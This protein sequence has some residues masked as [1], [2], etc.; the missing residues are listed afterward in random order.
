MNH[1]SRSR[2]LLLELLFDLVIFA[3]CAAVCVAILVSARS[4]SRES[5][6][7]TDAVYLAQSAAD[8]GTSERYEQDG[9][10]VSIARTAAAD[11]PNIRRIEIAKDGRVIYTLDVGVE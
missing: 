6:E 7:L 11:E 9:Y 2:L 8:A 1:S 5:R 3:L 4:M 10:T